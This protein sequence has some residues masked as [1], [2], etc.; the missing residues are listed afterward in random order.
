MMVDFLFLIFSMTKSE[1]VDA[2]D[3]SQPSIRFY[4]TPHQSSEIVF[5]GL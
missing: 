5:V 3:M 2:V 1:M 4:K